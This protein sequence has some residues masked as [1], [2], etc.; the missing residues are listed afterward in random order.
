MCNQ[1][2]EEDLQ[3]IKDK[4]IIILAIHSSNIESV[5]ASI[6]KELI[7]FEILFNKQIETKNIAKDT[8]LEFAAEGMRILP[9]ITNSN[10]LKLETLTKSFPQ[11]NKK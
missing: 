5:K 7:I 2:S 9:G 10:I 6:K 11:S 8:L 3:G 4:I 1:V